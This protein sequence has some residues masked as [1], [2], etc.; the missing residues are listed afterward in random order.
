VGAEADAAA[1]GCALLGLN[2]SVA[3]LECTWTAPKAF[4]AWGLQVC[5]Y[6]GAALKY[7]CTTVPY[8]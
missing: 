8:Y 3:G 1:F 2:S 7:T 5:P 4:A 6:D